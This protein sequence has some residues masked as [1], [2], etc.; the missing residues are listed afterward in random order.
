MSGYTLGW[1][2]GGRCDIICYVENMLESHTFSL[3]VKTI[4]Y[5]QVV[6]LGA[7]SCLLAGTS[8]K[9]LDSQFMGQGMIYDKSLV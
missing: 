4:T 5:V 2:G 1:G 8:L 9:I 3:I 7:L 6:A